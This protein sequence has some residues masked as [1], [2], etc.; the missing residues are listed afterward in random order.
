MANFKATPVKEESSDSDSDED[1][2]NA[3]TDLESPHGTFGNVLHALSFGLLGNQKMRTDRPVANEYKV[4]T[5]NADV[6]G[7]MDNKPIEEYSEEG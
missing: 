6:L 5:S 2:A 3:Q 4:K 1:D 7:P